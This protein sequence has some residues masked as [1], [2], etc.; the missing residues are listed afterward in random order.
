MLP[1]RDQGWVYLIIWKGLVYH[2]SDCLNLHFYTGCHEC[3]NELLF[4][5][6]IVVCPNN[7]RVILS[8]DFIGQNICYPRLHFLLIK[9]NKSHFRSRSSVCRQQQC[10]DLLSVN[11]FLNYS[12]ACVLV[13]GPDRL[14]MHG[15]AF[16]ATAA[17]WCA[18]RTYSGNLDACHCMCAKGKPRWTMMNYGFSWV[19]YFVIAGGWKCWS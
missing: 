19:H 18:N 4:E 11:W 16:P 17:T 13:E 7:L 8:I 9:Y 6:Q 12:N 10:K 3:T 14:C 5:I 15:D 2:I 1:A